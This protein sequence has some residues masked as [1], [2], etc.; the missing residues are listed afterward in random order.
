MD[1]GINA[2]INLQEPLRYISFSNKNLRPFGIPATELE[3]D[4]R[5]IAFKFIDFDIICSFQD[6]IEPGLYSYSLTKT[7]WK[8]MSVF[9]FLSELLEMTPS[10]SIGENDKLVFKKE[11]DIIMIEIH[12]FQENNRVITCHVQKEEE[13]FSF[14]RKMYYT[15][16]RFPVTSSN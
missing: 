13:V 5:K 3:I 8:F 16:K 14:L 4:G 7:N 2:L 10:M 15:L 9:N 11:N 6:Y 12:V 1:A